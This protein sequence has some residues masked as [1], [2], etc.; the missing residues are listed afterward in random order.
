MDIC[1]IH[2]H[3]SLSSLTTLSFKPLTG[4]GLRSLFSTSPCTPPHLTWHWYTYDTCGCFLSLSLLDALSTHGWQ[5][6]QGFLP[7]LDEFY[8]TTA[9]KKILENCRCIVPNFIN[10]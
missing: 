3:L 5:T 1:D 7:Q 10:D 2:M 6:T 8:F 4:G 9:E